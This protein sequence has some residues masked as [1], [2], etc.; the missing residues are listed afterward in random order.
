MLALAVGYRISELPERS[1][2]ED[3]L[4]SWLVMV[5]AGQPSSV[6]RYE[7]GSSEIDAEVLLRLSRISRKGMEWILTG[8]GTD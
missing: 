6:S 7:Q 5:L 2:R 4:L 8:R 3:S 1:D